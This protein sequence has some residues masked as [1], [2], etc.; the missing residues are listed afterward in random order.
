M[1]DWE[2]LLV[3]NRSAPPLEG[4]FDLSWH[5]RARVV[6][7]E[8]LGLNYARGA[9]FKASGGEV[10]IYVDDDNILA[11]DYLAQ[12]ERIARDYPFLGAWGGQIFLEFEEPPTPQEQAYFYWQLHREFK[13]IR[14]MN[15]IERFSDAPAGAGLV[16]RSPVVEA[17]LAKLARDPLRQKLGRCGTGWGSREDTD[18]ALTSFDL[19]LGV[20][21]FPSLTLRHL[22]P[23]SRLTQDHCLKLAHGE[24]YSTAI[25]N[26]ILNLPDRPEARTLFARLRRAY[27]RWRMSPPDR[28]LQRALDQGWR[29][30]EKFLREFDVGVNKD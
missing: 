6:V 22:T 30:A 19:D 28:E 10:L 8:K 27:R 25:L 26:R 14:W 11:P 1:S 2:L 16:V 7:E 20:G 21:Q 3:D 15:V 17:Y 24:G 29:E 4:R 23:R 9:G 18:L 12:A 5:P 13:A